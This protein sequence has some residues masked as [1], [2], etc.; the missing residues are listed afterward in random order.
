MHEL[1]HAVTVDGI[2][3]EYKWSTIEMI[4]ADSAFDI[5]VPEDVTALKERWIP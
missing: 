1:F 3:L 2:C 4:I 5:S